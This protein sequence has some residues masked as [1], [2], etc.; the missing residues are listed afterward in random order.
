MHIRSTVTLFST[1]IFL[2]SISAC[3]KTNENLDP[4]S[5]A[6][7]KVKEAESFVKRK[8]YVPYTQPYKD[9]DKIDYFDRITEAHFLI[10]KADDAIANVSINEKN[11]SEVTDLQ[12]KLKELK[13]ISLWQGSY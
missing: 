8:D 9:Y 3:K 10:A 7:Q 4:L 11:R 5:A 1:I 2:L 12:K 13:R 6:R